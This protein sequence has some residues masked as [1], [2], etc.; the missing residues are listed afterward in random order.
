MISL[1]P[2]VQH[3]YFLMM[4][5]LTKAEGP[6]D[7]PLR[8]KSQ[9]HDLT[10][11]NLVLDNPGELLVGIEPNMSGPTAHPKPPTTRLHPAGYP[12]ACNID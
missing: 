5:N 6:L 12:Q 2:S 10:C 4:W 1:P 9:I 11:Q 8:S 3:F 7:P